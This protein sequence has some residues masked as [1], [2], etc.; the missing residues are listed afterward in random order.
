MNVT[1]DDIKNGKCQLREGYEYNFIGISKDPKYPAVGQ[2]KHRSGDWKLTEHTK[3]GVFLSNEPDNWLDLVLKPE[4]QKPEPD[5][6]GW[7]RKDVTTSLDGL[8]DLKFSDGTEEIGVEFEN[9][10]TGYKESFDFLKLT[11]WRPHKADE[12][13]PKTEVRLYR[14]IDESGTTFLA[15][16][17]DKDA[18][19]DARYKSGA[20][21]ISWPV[22]LEEIF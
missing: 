19:L 18:A 9:G 6:D 15:E 13:K 7:I 10:Y 3:E 12:V 20:K 5:A 17:T 22:T 21:L 8:C 1:L 2:F 4:F 16:Y 14:W 11:H